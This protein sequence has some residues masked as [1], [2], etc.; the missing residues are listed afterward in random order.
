MVIVWLARLGQRSDSPA[1]H[2]RLDGALHLPQDD[3]GALT[4][5]VA[6]GQDG[7]AGV[8]L[9]DAGEV[10]RSEICVQVEP[11]AC[12]QHERQTDCDGVSEPQGYVVLVQ[13][14]EKAV[15]D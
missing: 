13:L 15:M 8:E 14:V 5:D 10:L 11:A 3:A 2:A 1:G 7:V 6:Q 9:A 4:D 12:Q